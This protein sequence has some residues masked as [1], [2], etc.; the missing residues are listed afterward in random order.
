MQA[1]A[2]SEL[3]RDRVVLVSDAEGPAVEID[4]A[5]G[6]VTV[7]QFNVPADRL[8][9]AIGQPP[10]PEPPDDEGNATGV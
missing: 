9:R 4:S 1:S 5:P 6:P 10:S 3:L 2:V 8:P 7:I